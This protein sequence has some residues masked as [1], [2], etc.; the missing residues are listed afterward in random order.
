MTGRRLRIVFAISQL[1]IGG[2]ERQLAE[3]ASRLGGVFDVSVIA[4]YSGGPLVPWLRARGVHVIVL[5]R[6]PASRR[7]L[8]APARILNVLLSLGRLYA[9]LRHERPDVFHGLL[10]GAYVP[11]TLLARLAGVPVVVSSRRSLG[12]Y[13]ANNPLLLTAERLATRL[14]DLTLANSHAVLEDVR[15][16]EQIPPDRLRVVW[17]AVEPQLP[18][19]AMSAARAACGVPLG[20]LCGVVVA[21]LIP[22]KGHRYLI[23]AMPLVR[24]ACGDVHLCLVGDG[25]ER[26]RLERLGRE[27][28]VGELLHFCGST[29]HVGSYI[30]AADI[31]ILPS[32]QEGL[33]NALLEMMAAGLPVIATSVGGNVDV[34]RDGVNGLLV[35]PAD[36]QHLADAITRLMRAPDLRSRLGAAAR[37]DVAERFSYAALVSNMTTIYRELALR[38]GAL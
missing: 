2:T 23:E 32:L 15:V 38:K 7:P 19:M 35:R 4:L 22:Y 36:P 10:Y 11:G 18:R 1:G 5:G 3:L 21:N 29:E 28:G 8:A 26:A 12:L 31:G 30:R 17:N 33:S 6:P 9:R 27:R 20:A 16:R 14:T 13:K 24:S 25:P 34:V 37:A